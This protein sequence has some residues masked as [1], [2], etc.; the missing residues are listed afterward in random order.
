MP[1][2]GANY[3]ERENSPSVPWIV[4]L[5]IF[6][7][8]LEPWWKPQIVGQGSRFDSLVHRLRMGLTRLRSDLVHHSPQILP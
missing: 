1:E 8:D 6:G 5:A 3:I 7:S 4:K 2:L